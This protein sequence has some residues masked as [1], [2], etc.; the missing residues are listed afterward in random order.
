[1]SVAKSVLSLPN[2]LVIITSL[3]SEEDQRHE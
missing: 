2:G 3:G 1:M